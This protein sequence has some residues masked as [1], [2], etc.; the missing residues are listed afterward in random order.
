MWKA[1]AYYSTKTVV[2]Y[3]DNRE[4]FKSAHSSALRFEFVRIN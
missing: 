4:W 3:V 2:D 1:T